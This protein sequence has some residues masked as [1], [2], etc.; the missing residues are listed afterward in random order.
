MLFNSIEFALF[1]PIVFLIYWSIAK[2]VKVQNVFLLTA[3]YFFYA[4]W[5]W[6]YLSLVLLCSITNYTAGIL[7][8]NTDLQKRRKIILTICCLVSFCVLGIFKYYDFFV[9]SFVS[10]FDLIGI[11]LQA[12]ILHLIMPV[13]ISFYTFHTLSYTIDVYRRKLEPTK[14]IVSFFLFVSIFPLAMAGPIERATNLLPQIYKRR[15]FDYALA[16]DGMRQIL[17]G[18]FKKAVIADNCATYANQIFDNYST[19]PGGTLLLGAIFFTFQIYGDF[20]GYSDMAL[21]VGK[22]LGFNF[23]KNFSF[24]YFSRN[25]AE[26]WK[27]WHISLNTWFQDYLYIPL[28]GSRGT[29]WQVV[30]NTF[31]I[32]LVSGFWHGANW[33]FI[34]WGTYH[35]LLFLPSILLGTNRKY[36][37]IVA[38]N[39][40]LPSIKELFQMGSTFFLVV[41]GWIFFRANSITEAV[42]YISRILSKSLFSFQVVGRK[43]TF[44]FILICMLVEWM[45]RDKQFGLQ[46]DTQSNRY[47]VGEGNLLKYR[48]IRW[49]LYL[50]LAFIIIIFRGNQA[51]FIYFQF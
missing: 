39:R 31:I 2:N 12:K 35:A 11:H 49:I 22:L 34:A 27:R 8:M 25:I 29:K 19:L 23:L 13:G 46:I 7:M 20:S 3:S 30:R 17:W 37:N 24:P 42:H 48:H 21:G 36:K 9:T 47:V 45:F 28:G 50:L 26:F 33:T 5:D 15:T 43:T 32:F 10:A 6:R 1:L 4:W 44:L 38:E 40:I 41:F 16:V 18:L 51:E 14:D